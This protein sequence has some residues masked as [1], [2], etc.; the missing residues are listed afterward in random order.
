MLGT[1]ALLLLNITLKD[2]LMLPGTSHNPPSG[3]WPCDGMAPTLT[4][5]SKLWVMPA[6]RYLETWELAA[7]MGVTTTR[8]EPQWTDRGMVLQARGSGGA[9]AHVWL[10]LGSGDGTPH[11]VRG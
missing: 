3:A 1:L 9:R 7:L 2:A 8:V 4:T 5:T 6:R 11:W 10:S